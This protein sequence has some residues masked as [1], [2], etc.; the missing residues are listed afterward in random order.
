MDGYK[1][2][3]RQAS[4]GCVGR[5]GAARKIITA[6]GLELSIASES[7]FIGERLIAY[8]D[9]VATM[10]VIWRASVV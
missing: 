10:Q 6:G 7:P 4:A 5:F 2:V 8:V 3:D 9:R 1:S